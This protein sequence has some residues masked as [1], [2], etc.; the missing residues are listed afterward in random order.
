MNVTPNVHNNIATFIFSLN[1]CDTSVLL[2]NDDKIKII[3]DKELYVDVTNVL[4]DDIENRISFDVLE[5]A[6][7]GDDNRSE[8]LV[9][10]KFVNDYHYIDKD[11]IFAIGMGA[12][13]KVDSI[14]TGSLSKI[15]TLETSLTRLL[16]T[17]N[18][19]ETSL[20]SAL[21][22]ISLLEKK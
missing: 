5:W 7:V 12:I 2:K 9:Y 6:T 19:L 13:K 4:K 14:L 1:T 20:I 17:I 8:L 15:N 18:T 16:S 3:S 10:G 21:D 11:K 22:R